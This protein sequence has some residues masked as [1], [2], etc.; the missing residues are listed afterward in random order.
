MK[1]ER[2]TFTHREREIILKKTE[3]KCAHCGAKLTAASMTIDHVLPV[4]RGGLNDEYN[5][6]PLCEN[7][8]EKKSS[9]V[10][11]IDDYYK[12][13][14]PEEE[15]KYK[16]YQRFATCSYG[17]RHIITYDEEVLISHNP[18]AKQAVIR[19]AK[20]GRRKQAWELFN[21]L[22]T[23]MVLKPAYP[24]DAPRLFDAIQKDIA[25]PLCLVDK[26][27][28]QNVDDVERAINGGNVYLLE[29]SLYELGGFFMFEPAANIIHGPLP[30]QLEN[31]CAETNLK[32]KYVMTFA[33][34]TKNR[35]HFFNMAMNK[36][37]E[38]QLMKGWLPL[39]VNILSLMYSSANNIYRFPLDYD[40]NA[41]LECMQIKELKS[42][43]QRMIDF[44]ISGQKEF[45]GISS[46]E[47]DCL[48]ESVLKYVYLDDALKDEQFNMLAEKHPDIKL[49]FSPSTNELFNVGF[50]TA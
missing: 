30:V 19:A 24:A 43:T 14:I 38:E 9:F 36:L 49:W 45:D 32:V 15:A 1:A 13:I 22:G 48:T 10:Y 26:T 3:C 23:K 41:C 27:I 7:C 5:L 44:A 16:H 18:M 33:E 47:K 6:L 34:A 31:L 50:I 8:N 46:Y 20:A 11:K 40:F 2:R 12:H 29:N 28:Y 21:R 25:D 39:Y 42:I 17:R 37:L 4:Y 35:D